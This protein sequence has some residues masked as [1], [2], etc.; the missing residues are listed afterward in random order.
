VSIKTY[1]NIFNTDFVEAK[2]LD[3]QVIIFIDLDDFKSINDNYGHASGDLVL[4]EMAIRLLEYANKADVYRIG[5]DEL[6]IIKNKDDKKNI[7]E[8]LETIKRPIVDKQKEYS[9]SGSIGF[10]E[11]SEFPKLQLSEL[12]NLADYAM[13]EAKAQGKGIVLKVTTEMVDK[14]YNLLGK[15]L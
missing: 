1:I 6:L 9:V 11:V 15:G 7:E 12:I 2:Q 10:L 4:K 13:L 8:L 14:Y 5:G 3:D